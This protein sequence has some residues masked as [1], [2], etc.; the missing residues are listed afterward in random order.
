MR[1]NT[2]YGQWNMSRSNNKDKEKL[3][4]IDCVNGV[5][6]C[7]CIYMCVCLF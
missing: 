3:I 6:V 4:I 1:D 5:A 7:E 2:L